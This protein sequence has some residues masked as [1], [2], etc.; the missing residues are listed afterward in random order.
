MHSLTV[1][2]SAV[3]QNDNKDHINHVRSS[4][5]NSNI[6]NNTRKKG[7][8]ERTNLVFYDQSTMM[9][10]SGDPGEDQSELRSC[11]KVEVDVLVSQ[12]VRSLDV[13]QR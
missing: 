11:V 6:Y 9:D 12:S 8:S 10:I 7:R 1:I 13:K 2:S 4:H 3:F 5:K